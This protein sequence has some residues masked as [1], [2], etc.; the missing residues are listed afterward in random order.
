MYIPVPWWKI[1]QFLFYLGRTL[2][3]EAQVDISQQF[4]A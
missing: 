1:L 3:D 4:V 2:T